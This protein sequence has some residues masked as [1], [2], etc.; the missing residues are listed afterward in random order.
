MYDCVFLFCLLVGV[1]VDYY[2][3]G[4]IVFFVCGGY[5]YS[6]FKGDIEILVVNVF[7]GGD[8]NIEKSRNLKEKKNN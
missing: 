5:C 1:G 7:G 3:N 4:F 2:Y 6:L 8:R